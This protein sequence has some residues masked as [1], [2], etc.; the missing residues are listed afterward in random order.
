M[1]SRFKRVLS[2]ALVL[3]LCLTL[4]PSVTTRVEAAALSQ[5]QFDAKLSSARSTYPT[6]SQRE[7]WSVNGTVVGWQCH[8]YGRWLSWYVWGVD[9]ANGNGSGWTLRKSSSSS[10]YI[11]NLVPGDVVRFRRI[12]SSGVLK[13]WNH[14]IF[15]TSI[16]GDT[17]YYTDCNSDGACTIK[18]VICFCM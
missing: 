11:N 9:F 4:L 14:T 16:I 10:S 5:S 7:E 1:K 17:I 3:C 13:T 2:I 18:L 8:G 15:I 6:G 12:S